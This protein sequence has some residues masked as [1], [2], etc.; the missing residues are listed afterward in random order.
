M[1]LDS[2][3][4][5]SW[6]SFL[7]KHIPLNAGSN[8]LV[9]AIPGKRIS[10]TQF[11]LSGDATVC[12]DLRSGDNPIFSFYGM[13]YFGV[14]LG[15][16]NEAVPLFITNTGESLNLFISGTVNANVYLRFREVT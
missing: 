6:G 15:A 5:Q 16:I 9:D 12:Y 14:P 2:F 13:E 11:L 1:T 4:S 10:V 7:H 3:Y 8:V